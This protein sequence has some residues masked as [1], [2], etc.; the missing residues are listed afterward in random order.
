MQEMKAIRREEQK[1]GADLMARIR[2]QW[3]QI[4]QQF[5]EE[6]Q[7]IQR[8]YEVEIENMSRYQKREMEKLE[9][10]QNKELQVEQKKLRSEQVCLNFNTQTFLFC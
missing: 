8:K 1:Q 5:T 9:I 4:D 6:E 10:S 2:A 7:N 3:D